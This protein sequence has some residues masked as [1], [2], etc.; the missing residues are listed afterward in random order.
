MVI[1]WSPGRGHG[2]R[3]TSAAQVSAVGDEPC[4]DALGVA[5]APR[6]AALLWPHLAPQVRRLHVVLACSALRIRC[7]E[8]WRE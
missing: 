1:R 3:P 7:H 8:S 2:C 6:A 4:G 5:Q